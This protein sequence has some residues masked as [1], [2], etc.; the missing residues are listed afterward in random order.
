MKGRIDVRSLSTRIA[1]TVALTVGALGALW[2]WS[3][4]RGDATEAR[5]RESARLITLAQCA[6]STV[7]GELLANPSEAGKAEVRDVLAELLQANGLAGEIEVM[8]ALEESR[9]KIAASPESI[10]PSTM[11]VLASSRDEAPERAAYEP[12]MRPALS[13]KQ[14]VVA[15]EAD[16]AGR[17]VGYAPVLDAFGTRVALLR[18]A[19]EREAPVWHAGVKLAVRVALVS[20]LVYGITRL[21]VLVN[22]RNLRPL[23]EIQEA[24]QR[25]ADG[26]FETP[27]D[28]SRTTETRE[29][30]RVLE[31]TRVH[32]IARMEEVEEYGNQRSGLAK[33]SGLFL[34]L[35]QDLRPAMQGFGAALKRLEGLPLSPEAQNAARHAA[36]SGHTLS[37]GL[38]E[39]LQ[40]ARID[41]GPEV[42]VRAPF[43]LTGTLQQV[44]YFA[45]S[46]SNERG[47]E[48]RVAVPEGLPTTLVGDPAG[49]QFVLNELIFNA[50]R[51]TDQGSV[52]LQIAH[53]GT[54]A[55]GATALRFMVTDT[56]AGMSA[57]DVASLAENLRRG[58]E[59]GTLAES[60]GGLGVVAELVRSFGG[61]LGFRSE[62]GKGSSFHFDA[63]F[64]AGSATRPG[65]APA[66]APAAAAP[67][68]TAA[69]EPGAPRA[70]AA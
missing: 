64:V 37:H 32:M 15:R 18:V 23:E 57:T 14:A 34:R 24:A 17:L 40:R 42:A 12:A 44:A 7:H 47:V 66:A 67:G 70:H 21:I 31:E 4:W 62:P 30:G 53:L 28:A 26:D 19:L 11:E 16:A 35:G 51:F 49:L 68:P 5:E 56:G 2:C 38:E 13:G 69:G 36:A 48:F 59:S 8:R 1:G 63:R 20:V 33:R 9:Q 29:L 6:A 41:A 54:D 43:Q 65:S 45:R 25:L 10:H 39:I 61:A 58:L 60:Y 27:I 55:E 50:Y 46:R 22:R 3:S 52:T